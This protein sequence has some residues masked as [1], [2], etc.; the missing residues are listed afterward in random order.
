MNFVEAFGR[1]IRIEFI[2]GCNETE[3]GME[4]EGISL[5]KLPADF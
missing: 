3:P 1:K 4:G 2:P 5:C